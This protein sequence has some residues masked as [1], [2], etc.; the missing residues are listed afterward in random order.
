MLVHVDLSKVTTKNELLDA[1]ATAL[2]FPSY[3]GRNWDALND[4]LTDL[5]WLDARGWQLN[6]SGSAAFERN[7]PKSFATL[8]EVLANAADYWTSQRRTFRVNVG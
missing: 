5:S 2:D 7:H 4:C 8:R 6:V 3:F 1:F